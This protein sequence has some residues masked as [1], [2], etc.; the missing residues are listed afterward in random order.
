VETFITGDFVTN[1]VSRLAADP[2]NLLD[3]LEP[4]DVVL[5]GHSLGR[6]VI[7]SY[8]DLFGG[9]RITKLAT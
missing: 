2:R 7:W 6:S 9:G 5:L 8:W 4:Y 3:E 1:D